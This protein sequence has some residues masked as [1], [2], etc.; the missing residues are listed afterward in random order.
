MVVRRRTQARGRGRGHLRIAGVVS[1]AVT[2]VELF[3]YDLSAL[4]TVARTVVLVVL[5][6][7]LLLASF[8][9]TKYKTRLGAPDAP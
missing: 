1:V 8:A 4:T 2:F 6:M 7:L 3:A 5:G 9:Y